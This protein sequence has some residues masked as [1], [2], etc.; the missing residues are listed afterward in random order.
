MLYIHVVWRFISNTKLFNCFWKYEKKSIKTIILVK[1]TNIVPVKRA[2]SFIMYKRIFWDNSSIRK[3]KQ[4][5]Q[6]SLYKGESPYKFF[7]VI[8]LFP[9]NRLYICQASNIAMLQRD[10][11]NEL[12]SDFLGSNFIS[13]C[14]MNIKRLLRSSMLRKMKFE[15]FKTLYVPFNPTLTLDLCYHEY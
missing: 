7:S 11:R 2:V 15:E 13:I 9:F 14:R 10:E 12:Y 8:V 1:F 3:K 5:F 4:H 6:F